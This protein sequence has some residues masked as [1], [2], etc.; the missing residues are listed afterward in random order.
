[1][2]SRTVGIVLVA[3]LLVA[4]LLAGAGWALSQAWY[5]QSYGSEYVYDVRVGPNYANDSVSN[6]T[7][8]LP[9]PVHEGTSS[10]GDAVTEGDVQFPDGWSYA[11]VETEHGRM[12]R[13]EADEIPGEPTYYRAV[14]EGDRLVDWEEIP[15]AEYSRNDS[16][17]I[18]IDHDDL[19]I[20][21]TV[22]VNETID[23]KSPQGNEPLLTPR[24]NQRA[25]DCEQFHERPGPSCYAYDT[26][27]YL[28][29]DA[30]P[31]TEMYVRVELSGTNSWWILGWNYNEY[32]DTVTLLTDESPDGWVTV[33]GQLVTGSGNYR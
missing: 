2:K 9:L 28:S 26:R 16:D 4:L 30:D 19:E 31:G 21:R 5:A 8:L 15:A 27:V 32:R 17:T 23:T 29:Y 11:V 14:M 18:R 3:V 10:I 6:V 33:D 7:V 22:S 1:M 13:L 12:L 20:R 25:V 24:S